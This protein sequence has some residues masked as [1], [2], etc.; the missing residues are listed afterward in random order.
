MTT[1]R[2]DAAGRRTT[3]CTATAPSASSL[4]ATGHPTSANAA[5]SSACNDTHH[6]HTTRDGS[7][8][9]TNAGAYSFEELSDCGFAWSTAPQKIR[10]QHRIRQLEN[11]LERRDFGIRQTGRAA[12]DEG[13]QQHIE[14]A[15]PA[16]ASPTEPRD[17][18]RSGHTLACGS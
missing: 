2:G 13:E 9:R 8:F 10:V 11:C 1:V 4:N 17:R 15:H 12:I 6:T 18:G 14:L 5:A 3:P 7:R 16:P